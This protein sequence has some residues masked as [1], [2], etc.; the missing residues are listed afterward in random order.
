MRSGFIVLYDLSL[1][2]FSGFP[3]RIYLL[4]P[5]LVL[6]CQNYLTPHILLDCKVD[7]S[8]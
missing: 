8:G 5:C 3:F 6:T 4:I 7:S 2:L 1:F